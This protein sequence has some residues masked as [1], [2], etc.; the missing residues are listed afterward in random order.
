MYNAGKSRKERAELGFIKYYNNDDAVTGARIFDFVLPIAE[1]EKIMRDQ[2]SKEESK[3]PSIDNQMPDLFVFGHVEPHYSADKKEYVINFSKTP[4]FVRSVKNFQLK[5]KTK[6]DV[7]VE[8]VKTSKNNFNLTV[9]WPFSIMNAFCLA[10]SA[11]D[12]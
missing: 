2:N 9:Q 1:A 7:V 5:W 11:F 3:H 8:L 4:K 12:V 10:L 6:P